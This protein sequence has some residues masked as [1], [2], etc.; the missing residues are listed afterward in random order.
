MATRSRK[1]AP[2]KLFQLYIVPEDSVTA[3]VV[4][5][6]TDQTIR[7]FKEHY[8]A[9]TGLPH[10]IHLVWTAPDGRPQ[11]ITEREGADPKTTPLVNQ[12]AVQD[13]DFIRMYVVRRCES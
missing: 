4:H 12:F 5:L 10:E 2:A 7:Q 6:R 9:K 13:G 8:F 1:S 3:R 11:T